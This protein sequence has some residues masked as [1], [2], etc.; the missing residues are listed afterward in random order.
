MT[1]ASRGLRLGLSRW[2][3]HGSYDADVPR[4]GLS[5]ACH[6]LRDDS[7]QILRD[8]LAYA[9]ER[10]AVVDEPDRPPDAGFD[11]LLAFDVLEHRKHDAEVLRSWVCHLKSDGHILVS[12]PAQQRKFR[13]SDEIVEHARRYEKAALHALLADAG[14]EDIRIVNY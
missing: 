1:S 7:R 14:I 12:I 3:R 11:H 4:Q 6:D 13:R 9:G 5:G 8:N 2:G 10:M